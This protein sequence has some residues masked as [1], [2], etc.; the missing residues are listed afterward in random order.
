MPSTV[1]QLRAALDEHDMVV[2][3]CPADKQRL[4]SKKCP[5]CQ[6]TL[7]GPCWRKLSAAHT[8]VGAVRAIADAEQAEVQ[9]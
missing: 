4:G 2:S 5:I 1:E 3:V 7:D 8:F 6:A 9:S